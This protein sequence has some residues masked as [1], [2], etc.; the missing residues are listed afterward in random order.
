MKRVQLQWWSGR[1]ASG[2]DGEVV[3]EWWSGGGNEESFVTGGDQ[4]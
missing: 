4:K 1:E 3:V 2:G